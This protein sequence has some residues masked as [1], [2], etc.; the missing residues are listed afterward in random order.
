MIQWF[1]LRCHENLYVIPA[2][3]VPPNPAELLGSSYTEAVIKA[4]S[5]AFDCIIFDLPRSAALQTD[6]LFQICLTE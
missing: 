4:L 6:L 2:G 3:D 1:S 5:A